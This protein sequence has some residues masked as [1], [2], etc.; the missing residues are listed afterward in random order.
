MVVASLSDSDRR[1]LGRVAERLVLFERG[2]LSLRA[3][4]GDLEILL[5]AVDAIDE[6]AR[7]ELRRHWEVLEEVYSVALG[8]HGGEFDSQSKGLV[9]DAVAALRLRVDELLGSATAES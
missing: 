3:L 7:R 2:E 5:G 1:T 4:I 6:T 9:R 8:M